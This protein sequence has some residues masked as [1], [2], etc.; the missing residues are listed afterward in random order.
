MNFMTI[1]RSVTELAVSTNM[2]R[3]SMIQLL[4]GL[5]CWSAAMISKAPKVNKSYARAWMHATSNMHES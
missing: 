3:F 2:A 1:H 5:Q 4:A